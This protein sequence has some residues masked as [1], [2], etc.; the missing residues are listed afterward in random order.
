MPFHRFRFAPAVLLAGIA[1]LPILH[2]CGDS[3]EPTAPVTATAA[4]ASA[5]AFSALTAGT[6]DNQTCGITTSSR[7]YC[8]G[9]NSLGSVGDGTTSKRLKPVPIGGVLRF[10][11]V[12]AGYGHVCAVTT[13]S[14]AYCWGI[15]T[16]YSSVGGQLGDGTLT[17]RRSPV[18]VLGGHAFRQVSTGFHHSCGVTTDDRAWCWGANVN[19]QLGDGTM[20]QRLTPVAV[21]GT[22]RFREVAAGSGHTCGITTDDRAYCW[23]SNNDGQIGDGGSRIERRLTPT[24]VAGDRRY[25]QVDAGAGHTCALTVSGRAY[26]WGLNRDGDIGD[27]KTNLRRFLPKAVAGGLSFSTIAAGFSGTCGTTTADRAYC[28]GQNQAGGVGDGTLTDRFVPTPVAGG[29]KFTQMTSGLVH[30]CART[31]EGAGFCWGDNFGGALGD[32]TETDRLQPKAIA[33]P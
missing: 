13:D 2:G 10:R 29:H 9:Y 15:N 12:N 4:A 23:G 6:G 11:Q 22:L 8:W 21:A 7:L 24:P 18:A 32:G 19:G 17:N 31:P 20:T 14:R 5:L 1:G 25:R 16:F 26:C 3:R 33:A 27:G 30:T 28:W